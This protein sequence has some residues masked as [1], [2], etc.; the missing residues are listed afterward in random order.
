MYLIMYI[1][2]YVQTETKPLLTRGFRRSQ[3]A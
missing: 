3:V 2:Q 1:V